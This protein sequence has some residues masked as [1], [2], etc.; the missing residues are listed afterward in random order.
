MTGLLRRR[1]N[2]IA[3]SSEVK[4]QLRQILTGNNPP[5]SQ[6]ECGITYV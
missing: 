2:N 3:S 1:R 6:D 4:N 5:T